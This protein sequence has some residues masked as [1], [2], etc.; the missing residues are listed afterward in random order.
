MKESAENSDKCV[1]C[2]DIV[3]DNQ[4]LERDIRKLHSMLI[5]AHDFHSKIFE[6]HSDSEAIFYINSHLGRAFGDP[7]ELLLVLPEDRG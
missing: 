7:D 2:K 1:V 6:R 3:L 4:E 5:A